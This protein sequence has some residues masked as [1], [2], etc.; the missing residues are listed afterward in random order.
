MRTCSNPKQGGEGLDFL[1][2]RTIKAP[3]VIES[4]D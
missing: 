3:A 4:E 2:T 1:K